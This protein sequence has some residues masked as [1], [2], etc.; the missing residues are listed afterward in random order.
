MRGPRDLNEIAMVRG[1]G[2]TV[3]PK[4]GNQPVTRVLQF[5]LRC[6]RTRPRKTI[7]W[8]TRQPVC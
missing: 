4:T 6:V 8:G 7:L 5:G 2:S 1:R 3:Y